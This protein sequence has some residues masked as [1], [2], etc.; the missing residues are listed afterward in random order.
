MDAAT[1]QTPSSR[2][3]KSLAWVCFNSFGDEKRAQC[4]SCNGVVT[5]TDAKC[6][7]RTMWWHLYSKH[8]NQHDKLKILADK[9]KMTYDGAR[10]RVNFDHPLDHQVAE[11]LP[12]TSDSGEKENEVTEIAQF[13]QDQVDELF[14]SEMGKNADIPS[15]LTPRPPRRRTGAHLAQPPSVPMSPMA[16]AL[17]VFASSKRRSV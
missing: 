2:L 10:Q 12:S 11:V 13:L 9:L 8:R 4:R 15:L 7:T 14:S 1:P 3:K 5:W 17:Q 16:A 6:T